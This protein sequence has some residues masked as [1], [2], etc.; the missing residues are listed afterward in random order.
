[1]L[2]QGQNLVDFTNSP[3]PIFLLICPPAPSLLFDVWLW[4]DFV[5]T[6][7]NAGQAS[8]ALHQLDVVCVCLCVWE[9]ERESLCDNFPP[10]SYRIKCQS[11]RQCAVLRVIFILGLFDSQLKASLSFSAERK[12][13]FIYLSD[14]AIFLS[15]FL[16]PA[17][18]L[19]VSF[20][21]LLHCTNVI[22]L[23]RRGW[24]VSMPGLGCFC[25]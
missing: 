13:A 5:S 14:W 11:N 17:L 22:V 3:S 24:L 10:L 9:R 2:L 23:K 12:G 25:F 16:S 8:A 21:F 19:W 15:L 7:F 1:M 4:T 18:C 20:S 6:F